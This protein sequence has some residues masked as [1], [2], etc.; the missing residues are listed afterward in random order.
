MQ[1]VEPE[2]KVRRS[3]LNQRKKAGRANYKE[4]CKAKRKSFGNVMHKDDQK[5]D[6]FQVA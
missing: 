4:K 3:I 6:L 1:G 2:I 5:L